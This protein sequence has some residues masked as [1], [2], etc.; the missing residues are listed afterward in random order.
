MPETL[1]VDPPTRIPP[2]ALISDVQARRLAEDR[3]RGFDEY[4]AWILTESV[5]SRI[6]PKRAELET[7]TQE[8]AL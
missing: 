5:E 6:A 1:P 8:E 3:I 2:P 7:R 4:K